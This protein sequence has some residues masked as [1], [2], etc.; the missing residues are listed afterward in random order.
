MLRKLAILFFFNFG[1][2]FFLNWRILKKIIQIIFQELFSN[3]YVLH[4]FPWVQSFSRLSITN[5]QTD[6]KTSKVY[7]K[8]IVFSFQI[9]LSLEF[10]IHI[11]FVL[12]SQIFSVFICQRDCKSSFKG[13]S[14]Q[15]WLCL[16][17]N[18]NLETC[19]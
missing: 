3:F 12:I 13:F 15:I 6:T 9:N 4:S 10:I 1:G 16:I 8:I 14:M 11:K 5:K 17:H 18:C 19:I 2:F 7:I